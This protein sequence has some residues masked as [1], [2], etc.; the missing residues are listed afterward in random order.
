MVPNPARKTT[1]CLWRYLPWPQRTAHPARPAHRAPAHPGPGR[2]LRPAHRRRRP[3]PRH[4]S[5][6]ALRGQIPP[7]PCINDLP[8]SGVLIPH[9]SANSYGRASLHVHSFFS[10]YWSLLRNSRQQLF[11]RRI[12]RAA[13]SWEKFIVTC[14]T[15]VRRP[16]DPGIM[17]RASHQHNPQSGT[18]PRAWRASTCNNKCVPPRP[19]PVRSRLV[20]RLSISSFQLPRLLTLRSN[21]QFGQQGRDCPISR[22]PSS[23]RCQGPAGVYQRACCLPRYS[24]SDN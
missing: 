1:H 17:W 3:L 14:I 13:V 8:M 10:M 19:L 7:K 18:A 6:P 16:K 12:N 15:S 20:S 24:G 9:H 23:G 4:R 11:S 21:P 5:R 22:G 2:P